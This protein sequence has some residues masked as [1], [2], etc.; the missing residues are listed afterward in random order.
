MERFTVMRLVIR[1]I[2]DSIMWPTMVYA[3]LYMI[4]V[5][6]CHVFSIYGLK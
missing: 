4:K 3:L 2:L 5:S 6:F 1:Y